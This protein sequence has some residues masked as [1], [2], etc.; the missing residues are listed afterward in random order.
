MLYGLDAVGRPPFAL[1]VI[2]GAAVSF[3]NSHVR[4]IFVRK[5]TSM[6]TDQIGVSVEARDYAR[7]RTRSVDLKDV[8][9]IVRQR[10]WE[11]GQGERT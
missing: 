7:R 3:L 6:S 9:G 5:S 1:T 10:T 8:F 2:T 4:S 11:V